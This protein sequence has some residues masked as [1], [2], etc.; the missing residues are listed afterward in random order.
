MKK[1]LLKLV[2]LFLP[3]IAQAQVVQVK[4]V[5][6]KTYSSSVTTEIK[7]MAYQAAQVA[8]VERY[9]AENGEAESQN[10]EAI[11]DRIEAN[12][13]KFILNVTV[14]NEQDQASLHKYSVAVRVEL[15]VA[16]LR[17]TLRGSS[18]VG[19]AANTEK[20]QLVYLFLGREVA[21]VRAFDARVVKR[22]EVSTS[23]KESDHV[24]VRGSESESISNASVGTSTSV[25][26][27]RN[28]SAKEV[29]NVETGGSVTQKADDVAYRLLSLSNTKTAITS[30]FSQG[31]FNVA[32]PEFVL[33]DSD[34][35]SV[36]RDF[37]GGN[38]L[39]PATLRAV[40]MSLRK[41]QVPLLVLATLD[42]GAPGQDP[43]TG[44]QRVA[45]TV[46]GRVLDVSN[47]LPREVASVPAIQYFGTGPDNATAM[48]SGLKNAA[49]AAAREVV[50]RLNAA[51]VH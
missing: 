8:A 10:F 46:T 6:T 34:F 39:A 15:N 12:L 50:S 44:L 36:N 9:F 20:S 29:V 16:K 24:T 47:N 37:S 35:K 30:V 27:N 3:I 26:A 23:L 51:G 33:A 49:Q 21:S 42:V 17:N 25:K 5:G 18:A 28:A 41:S 38:D 43:V 19:K 48:N 40:V 32:D 4:G 22:A 45:V 2:F 11:Q 7:E 14:L 13:D 1:L 31:G